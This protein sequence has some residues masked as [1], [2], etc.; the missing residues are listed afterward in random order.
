MSMNKWTMNKIYYYASKRIY[1]MI[2]L[3]YEYY[4]MNIYFNDNK[5]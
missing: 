2:I 1:I 4:N 3:Y 5:L